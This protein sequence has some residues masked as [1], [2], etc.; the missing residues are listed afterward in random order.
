MDVGLCLE[1][2]CG[3]SMGI[4]WLWYHD[5]ANG[6]K[7]VAIKGKS[8]VLCISTTVPSAL[9]VECASVPRGLHKYSILLVW[10]DVMPMMIYKQNMS[11][12]IIIYT[13]IAS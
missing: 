7:E 1:G 6:H 5:Y 9:L 11:Y 10:K 13:V 12:F 3:D 4:F 2:Y 8:F